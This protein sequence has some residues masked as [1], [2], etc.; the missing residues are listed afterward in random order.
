MKGM[1][2]SDARKRLE[3]QGHEGRHP[4]AMVRRES[5]PEA[6]PHSLDRLDQTTQHYLSS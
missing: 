4:E 1:A 2:R 5:E 6:S 3:E